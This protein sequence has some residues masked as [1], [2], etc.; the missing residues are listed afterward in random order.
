MNKLIKLSLITTL[1]LSTSVFAEKNKEKSV[2]SKVSDLTKMFSDGK[3]SGQIRLGYGANIVKTDGDKNTYATAVGGQLKYETASLMG[4]SFG[5]AMQ[6]SHSINGLS[7]RGDKYNNELASNEKSYTELAE[8]YLNFSYGG[9]EFRGG[10]QLIDTP[11]A[12][13]D[14]IRMTPHTFEAYIASYTF[15]DLGL[16]F[17]AGNISN[18]QGVDSETDLGE[19]YANAENNVWAKT[20][21]NGTRVGAVTYS[22]DYLDTSVW[23]YDVTKVTTAFYT[24]IVGTIPINDESEIEISAQYLTENDQKKDGVNSEI[25]GS[26]LGAMVEAKF[27]NITT[28][29]AYDKV[30]VKDGKSIFEGFGGGASYTN[31]DTMTAGALHDGTYGDGNSYKFGLSYEIADFTIFGA[32]GDYRADAIAGGVKAHVTEMNFGLEY[33]Y[34]DGEADIALIYVVGRDKESSTKTE[35]D[36]DRIQ[37]V[38]NYNF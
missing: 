30:S 14:D 5:V 11:L 16:S 29:L 13:S 1:A 36:N 25:E 19:P 12:D 8:A 28:T 38:L 21:E 20:G 18:W 17:I 32:Y 34:N 10:R 2:P 35:F 33:E 31:L 9:F 23:Y 37:V 15:K 26:I 7:G 24:E 3:V 22:T 6:T 27:Y 4:L